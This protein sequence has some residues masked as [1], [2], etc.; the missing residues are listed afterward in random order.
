MG[1]SILNKKLKKIIS[2][3]L[4]ASF[5]TTPISVNAH[6]GKTDSS[7]GH[8]DNKNVSGLGPYHYHCVGYPAHLHENGVCPYKSSNTTSNNS[9]NNS[10]SSSNNAAAE[11]KRAAELEAQR[12]ENAK[13]E[14]RTKGYNQGYEDGYNEKSSNPS[15]YQSQYQ[16][17]FNDGYNEGFEKGQNTVKSEK[18]EI[19]KLATET[20]NNDGYSG[21]ENHSNLY[22]GKHIDY[23]K[24]NYNVAYNS[25]LNKRNTEIASTKNSAFIATLKGETLN[26]SDYAE[27]HNKEAAKAGS[28]LAT[29]LLKEYITNAPILG[30]E[31]I[32]FN[33]FYENKENVTLDNINAD[34]FI[35]IDNS[36]TKKVKAVKFN[37]NSINEINFSSESLEALINSY[38]TSDVLNAYKLN[39]AYK[40]GTE[41]SYY[42]VYR[43]KCTSKIKTTL[44]KKFY[45]IV[46]YSNDN[47]DELYI[48]ESEP[49]SIKK[50]KKSGKISLQ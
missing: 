50:V 5:I 11:A 15:S 10:S 25:S 14:E 29:S 13:N 4:L 41:K 18:A 45:I 20:G 49:K 9:S 35:N 3:I 39:S 26:E 8:K 37:L 27:S 16:S 7:G 28:E 31:L 42:E 6:S 36:S 33:K 23:Y 43:L 2:S 30:E 48:S 12:I 46:S 44:P 24:T 21:S 32:N 47:L 1:D 19:L 34:S 38:L 22:D 17:N 40:R